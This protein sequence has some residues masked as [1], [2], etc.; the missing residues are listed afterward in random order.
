MYS[1]TFLLPSLANRVTSS[2]SRSQVC[3][4]HDT[5]H[6]SWFASYI[7]ARSNPKLTLSARS[8]LAFDYSC[9]LCWDKPMGN[10]PASHTLHRS[11]TTTPSVLP[12]VFAL[13]T[14]RIKAFKEVQ[15]TASGNRQEGCKCKPGA[16]TEPQHARWE[17]HLAFPLLVP[18]LT[19]VWEAGELLTEAVR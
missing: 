16:C 10:M 6:L 8:H 7:Y 19:Q 3:Y 18:S 12:R 1:N 4:C 14:H 11:P 9:L 5:K 2:T 15:P 17:Q 13:P